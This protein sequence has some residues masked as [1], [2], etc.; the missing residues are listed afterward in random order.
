MNRPR[1]ERQSVLEPWS[2]SPVLD[3]DRRS[4]GEIVKR[5]QKKRQSTIDPAWQ[6]LQLAIA[7]ERFEKVPDVLSA[8]EF[9]ELLGVTLTQV[10]RSARA[11]RIQAVRNGD[12][13]SWN[14]L[15]DQNE[16]IIRSHFGRKPRT[17]PATKVCP[18]E[19]VRTLVG[20]VAVAA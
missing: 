14:I 16:E 8:R 2:T 20:N 18:T 1:G 13:Q 12:D 7:Q 6:Q 19:L 15:K 5:P 9:A 4:N 17:K 10:R 3:P 11:G